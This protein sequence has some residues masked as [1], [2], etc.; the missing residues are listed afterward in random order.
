MEG[1]RKFA[2]TATN[3]GEEE[4]AASSEKANQ[5]D[6]EPVITYKDPVITEAASTT[7]AS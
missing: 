2:E 6:R 7:S 4:R 1:L 3:I 5:D